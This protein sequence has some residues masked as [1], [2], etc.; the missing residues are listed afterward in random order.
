ML[1]CK[2]IATPM[3]SNLK[4]LCDASSETIDATMY[5]RMICSL[6]CLTNTRLDTCFFVNDLIQ[7]LMDLRRAY[8]EEDHLGLLIQFEIQYGILVW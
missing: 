6:M 7:F 2:A 1:D 3:E 4:L 5:R 8:S